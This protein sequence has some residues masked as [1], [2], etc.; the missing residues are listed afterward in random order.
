MLV[1][2]FLWNVLFANPAEVVMALSAFHVIAAPSF[3]NRYRTGRTGPVLHPIQLSK[4]PKLKLSLDP[5]FLVL[6]LA[7]TT[8]VVGLPTNEAQAFKTLRTPSPRFI[9]TA[10][11]RLFYNSVTVR[12]RAILQLLVSCDIEVSLR[13]GKLLREIGAYLK[14]IKVFVLEFKFAAILY[15]GNLVSFAFDGSFNMF[16][17]AVY[18]AECVVFATLR[19]TEEVGS[20]VVELAAYPAHQ[21]VFICFRAGFRWVQLHVFFLRVVVLRGWAVYQLA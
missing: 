6:A 20:G 13:S 4:F 10:T 21:C 18:T 14:T 3:L 5:S 8:L 7:L 17:R 11:S 15:A 16:G 9:F 19:Q 1:R 2:V 12:C